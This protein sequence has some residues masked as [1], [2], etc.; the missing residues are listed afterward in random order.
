MRE[1][2]QYDYTM[3]VRFL[4]EKGANPNPGTSPRSD[5]CLCIA[6]EHGSLDI[7]KA[8]LDAGADLDWQTAYG[9]TAL[10]IAI[11]NGSLAIVRT[12]LESSGQTDEITNIP[13][14]KATQLIR[15]VLNGDEANVGA[16]L[17]EWPITEVSAKY[18]NVALWRAA[19]RG[20]EKSIQLLLEKGADINSRVRRLPVLFAAARSPETGWQDKR[21]L[22]LIQVL[23][24]Q[25]A[26][27]HV[28]YYDSTLL[29]QAI[30]VDKVNLARILLEEGADIHQGGPASPL[31]LHAVYHYRFDA[32][33]F[34]LQRGADIEREGVPSERHYGEAPHSAL[35]W[36]RIDW[37]YP[38][39]AQFLLKHG[40]KDGPGPCPHPHQ[41]GFCPYGHG[42]GVCPH[43]FRRVEDVADETEL[44]EAEQFESDE[45]LIDEA[46]SVGSELSKNMVQWRSI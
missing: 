1:A 21:N 24:R 38:N 40:A 34:L 45:N 36:A 12:V 10:D 23:L 13:W 41:P 20:K 6:A 43:E 33:R 31:L 32:A 17:R 5:P 35:Y 8:L 4:L 28:T 37:S 3:V 42:P 9:E 29:Y 16:I 27:P 46:L 22:P 14:I 7:V 18:L 30:G 11:H 19:T 15:A 44:A 26:D 2:V 25:G 39:M